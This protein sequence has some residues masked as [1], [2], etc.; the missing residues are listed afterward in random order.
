MATIAVGTEKHN[1]QL[2]PYQWFVSGTRRHPCLLFCD[3]PSLSLEFFYSISYR[4]DH[5][6]DGF[7]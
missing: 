4:V 3:F 7:G 1:K 5:G 2:E 6:K